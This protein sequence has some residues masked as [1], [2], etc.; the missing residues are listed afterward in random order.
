MQNEPFFNNQKDIPDKR[1]ALNRTDN[2]LCQ[3]LTKDQRVLIS[4]WSQRFSRYRHVQTGYL[5]D[6]NWYTLERVLNVPYGLL[7]RLDSACV[8]EA[9]D[10]CSHTCTRI[11]ISEKWIQIYYVVKS[12]IDIYLTRVTNGIFSAEIPVHT[13]ELWDNQKK[14]V[15]KVLS[16]QVAPTYFGLA[17]DHTVRRTVL[18]Q[19]SPIAHA[20]IVKNEINKKGFCG[21]VKVA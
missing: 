18:T 2:T 15:L 13:D 7:R 21:P 19:R 14:V 17:P 16:D 9:P 1:N 8:S 10:L 5:T 4:F 20:W 11:R 6:L 12:D 3:K